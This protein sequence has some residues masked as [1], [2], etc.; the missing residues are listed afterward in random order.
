MAETQGKLRVRF[1][2]SPTGYL[3]IGGARTALFNYLYARRH[4]GVFVLRIEDTD[5]ERSTPESV[6]AIFDGLKFLGLDWDEGPVMGGGF[7]P[8]FQSQRLPIYQDL[9]RRLLERGRAYRCFCSRERLEALRKEQE[10]AKTRFH[11]DRRCRGLAED[12]VRARIG[13]GEPSVVRLAID[14]GE[15]VVE[16]LIRG[17]VAFNHRD[18]D[19]F[20]VQ[21]ADGTCIYNM[22]VVG[23]DAGMAISHVIRGED[24]LTNTPKQMLIFEALG[25]EPP[26]YAH[27]PLI[28][29]P[30]NQKLSKRHGA[31]SVTEYE[32]LGYLPEAMLNFLARMGWSYDD[33]EEIFS[34]ADLIAKF[35]LDGVSKSP[36]VYDLKKLEHLGGHYI[37]A[38]PLGDLVDLAVPRLVE[39]GLLR[40]EDAAACRPRLET[41]MALEKDR[42]V[43]LGQVV[44]RL[45]FYFQDLP[46]SAFEPKAAK[47]LLKDAAGTAALLA[48]YADAIEERFDPERPAALEEAARRL[49]ESRGIGL[50]DLAQPVRAAITGRTFSPPL[51]DILALVGKEACL[52]RLRGAASTI[53]ELEKTAGG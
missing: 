3:H 33:K 53:R 21:R 9:V 52:R 37:R 1:A 44:E 26:V 30:G 23:D 48:A 24:H 20:I 49:A 27:I 2:P 7:G 39:A 16:D 34:K 46:P 28:H 47:L 18:I 22:A 11:Y 8:Y 38:R 25:L 4:G 32:E 42:L 5:Q 51:F 43:R 19:D 36:A 17:R 29:G 13:A 10:A 31:V 50:G 41:M 6:Q 14:D 35:S 45:Q 12:E 40:A 15:T